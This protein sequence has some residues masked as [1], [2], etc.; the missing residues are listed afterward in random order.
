M[1]NVQ[2]R[3]MD[4]AGMLLRPLWAGTDKPRAIQSQALKGMAVSR[5]EDSQYQPKERLTMPYYEVT[6]TCSKCVCVKAK[7][8][9]SAEEAARD[10]LHGDWNRCE[11]EWEGDIDPTKPDDKAIIKEYKQ[12]GEF[13]DAKDPE[14]EDEE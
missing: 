4:V 14:C 2:R 12:Q 11:A 1:Q 3:S 13:V 10:A 7:D 5:E 8:E 6:V 9:S